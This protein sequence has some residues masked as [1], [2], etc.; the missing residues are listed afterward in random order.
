MNRNLV[1]VACLFLGGCAVA[2]YTPYSG[3]Q[4]NWPVSSGT[5]VDNKY[6]VP[7]FYGAPNRPYV[8]LGYLNAE[9]APVRSRR[10]AVLAFMARR[11]QE[12]GGNGLIVLGTNREY[13]GSVSSG[14]VTGNVWSCTYEL[15]AGGAITAVALVLRRGR[16]RSGF[17]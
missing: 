5:F 3:T 17:V 6:A 10:G 15:L 8:V 2:D 16:L 7:V 14:S 13:V 11:A 9:T 4:Q 12:L 1:L